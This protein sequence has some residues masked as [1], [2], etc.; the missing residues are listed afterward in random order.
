MYAGVDIGGTKTLVAAIDDSGAIVERIR[1]E[2]P[3]IYESFVEQFKI[4]AKDIQH[5]DFQAGGIG[6]PGKINRGNGNGMWFGNLDWK[7]VP[8]DHDIERILHCPMVI[9]NDAKKYSKVLYVTVSTGIG[10]GLVV[11]GKIDDAFSDRGG[12]S[13]LVEHAGSGKLVPWESFA[14]GHA[15]VTRYGKKAQDITDDHTWKSISRDIC[16]GLIELIAIAEPDVIIFG[17]SVGVYFDRFSDFL[18]QDLE[19]YKT[20]LVSIPDLRA[21]KRPEDAVLYGCYDLA[22]QTFSDLPNAKPAKVEA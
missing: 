3:K 10:Y 9:Q 12:T 13:I 2:T 20:P 11:N 4:A 18:T 21:A 6:A 17:G 22:K 19:R 8:L 7:N 16:R 14:S 1:F 5:H 15:I